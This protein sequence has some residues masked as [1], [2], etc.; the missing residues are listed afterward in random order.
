MSIKT[1]ISHIVNPT[2]ICNPAP[3]VTSHTSDNHQPH[4]SLVLQTA[5]SYSKKN[6]TRSSL[7]VDVHSDEA[8]QSAR[9][10][11]EYEQSARPN[12]FEIESHC[13]GARCQSKGRRRSAL[14]SFPPCWVLVFVVFARSV[15]KSVYLKLETNQTCPPN[16]NCS[17]VH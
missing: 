7:A 11:S 17:R 15:K 6:A 3:I 9:L 5:R 14:F 4:P 16:P 12:C 8:T 13:H 10:I 1:D 2:F